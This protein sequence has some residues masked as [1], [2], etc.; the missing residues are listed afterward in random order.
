[1]PY[2]YFPETLLLSL[3]IHALAAY[4][5]YGPPAEVKNQKPS[6]DST[7]FVSYVKVA[8]PEPAEK[9]IPKSEPLKP[10]INKTEPVFNRPPEQKKKT[11]PQKAAPKITREGTPLGDPELSLG[12]REKKFFI[13]YFSQVKQRISRTLREKSKGQMNRGKVA[14]L[15]VL[16]SNGHLERVLVVDQQS[17]AVDTAKNLARDS[18]AASAPFPRFPKELT[19]DRL[20]FHVTVYF[21]ER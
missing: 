11:F 16:A 10:K 14:L 7:I 12:P 17:D 20:S 18:L 3:S 4:S 2:R 15:F 19:M 5:F 8:A 9:I 6:E 13:D 21:E 1:M